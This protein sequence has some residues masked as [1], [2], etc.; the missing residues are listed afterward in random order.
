MLPSTFVPCF[1]HLAREQGTPSS[2]C[3]RRVGRN[4]AKI[5]FARRSRRTRQ[6]RRRRGSWGGVPQRTA[7][8]CA[9]R[10]PGFEVTYRYR[11][12]TYHVR[13]DKVVGAVV[14]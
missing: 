6:L 2:I 10:W 9:N 3:R 11:S 7:P 5:M 4:H 14:G 8:P 13:V 12:T 1:D